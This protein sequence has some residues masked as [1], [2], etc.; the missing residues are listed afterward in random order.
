[1]NIATLTNSNSRIFVDH[2]LPDCPEEIKTLLADEDYCFYVAGMIDSG[3]FFDFSASQLFRKTEKGIENLY[4]T[5]EIFFGDI[6]YLDGDK[7]IALIYQA[8]FIEGKLK[9]LSRVLCDPMDNEERKKAVGRIISR[10]KVRN[11]IQ[12]TWWFEYLYRP[13][14]ALVRFVFGLARAIVFLAFKI[15]DGIIALIQ[16][17]LAP[18]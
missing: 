13:W 6:F 17:L 1:M 10:I 9:S 15:L 18:L 11:K 4:H 14:R 7:D 3:C 5:G 8:T 16:F 12:N 2:P